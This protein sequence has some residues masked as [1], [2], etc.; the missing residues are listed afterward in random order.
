MCWL[1]SYRPGAS[2]RTHNLYWSQSLPCA[3][4]NGARRHFPGIQ[5]T[6]RRT[7][8]LTG[9]SLYRAPPKMAH[10]AIFPH[11]C[12]GG[13]ACEC[14]RGRIQRARVGAAVESGRAIARRRRFRAPQ[15]DI[16]PSEQP[17]SERWM[18]E[19][20]PRTFRARHFPVLAVFLH[21]ILS[22]SHMAASTAC[23]YTLSCR[24]CRVILQVTIK[25]TP[26][27][28]WGVFYCV[29]V[30]L[31]S[32]AA[33]SQVLSAPVSLTTV[34]GMGTGVPSPSSTPTS[35]FVRP[36]RSPSKPD[37]AFES[38]LEPHVFSCRTSGHH[39]FGAPKLYPHI[40]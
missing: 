26:C 6:F 31:S 21:R 40:P 36:S 33:S 11:F 19:E 3:L 34:F 18:Q 39:S 38:L 2:G 32:R 8:N 25:H 12:S 23:A 4:E 16:L 13:N 14:R 20:M 15:E 28:A 24:N 30:F 17:E 37:K 5:Q 7:H 29:G 35:S 1:S 9:H 27:V 22:H 10:G